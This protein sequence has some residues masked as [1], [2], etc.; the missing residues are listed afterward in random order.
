[1]ML[2]TKD[3]AVRLNVAVRT[4]RGWIS[5]GDLQVFQIGR[6]V[7]I[8]ETALHEFILSGC[9]TNKKAARSGGSPT[10]TRRANELSALLGRPSTR[11]QKRKS[12]S[13]DPNRIPS[14][15]VQAALK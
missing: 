9:R 12:K 1:M 10:Q 2:T 14:N 3:V 4:V 8:D 13:S 11:M 7:R 5:N 6:V 15:G